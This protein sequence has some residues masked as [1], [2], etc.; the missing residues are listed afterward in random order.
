MNY[1]GG[2]RPR[3]AFERDFP[4]FTY[5]DQGVAAGAALDIIRVAFAAVRVECQFVPAV[6][7]DRRLLMRRGEVDAWALLSV[8]KERSL[9]LYF[10]EPYLSTG[11]GIF[12]RRGESGR[13]AQGG[14]TSR[15]VTPAN[16]PLRQEILGHFPQAELCLAESYEACLRTVIEDRADAAALNIDVGAMLAERLY[17]GKFDLPTHPFL[18]TPVAVGACRPS[19]QSVIELFNEGLRIAAPE[20]GKLPSVRKLRSHACPAEVQGED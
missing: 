1:D 16:G 9:D 15:I 11:A 2:W 4:P 10:S 7:R 12:Y 18:A 8:S 3:V 14:V 6:M 13:Q 19:G 20:V 5:V 17:P